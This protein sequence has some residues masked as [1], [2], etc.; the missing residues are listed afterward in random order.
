MR[1]FLRL[2]FVAFAAV[3]V[4]APAAG[5]HDAHKVGNL[6]ISVGWR[7]EPTYA[8]LP[9]A[10]QITAVD[11]RGEPVV[12]LDPSLTTTISFGDTTTVRELRPLGPG[13]YSAA[14]VPTQPGT[15]S[16]QVVGTLSGQ[17]VDITSTCSDSTFDC[18][19]DASEV[20]FPPESASK[21]SDGS[22]SPSRLGPDDDS[23]PDAL[24]IVALGLSV[25]AIGATVALGIRSRRIGQPG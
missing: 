20:E 8:G 22:A 14:I 18:V 21:T 7:D 1:R 24:T 3:A 23:G 6:E 16:V 9:N 15:Y 10:M 13:V 25:L 2:A 11:D 17:A 12:D 19:A 4:T 5:A